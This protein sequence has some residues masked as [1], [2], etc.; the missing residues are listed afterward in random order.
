MIELDKG[1]RIG[2]MSF[3]AG[4]ICDALLKSLEVECEPHVLI[5]TISPHLSR[6]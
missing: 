2:D 5:R 6:C 3:E 4:M 1:E